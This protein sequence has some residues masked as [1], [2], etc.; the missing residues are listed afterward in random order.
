MP[1]L[2][3]GWNYRSVCDA[4]NVKSYHTQW[5]HNKLTTNS[6]DLIISVIGWTEKR[7][8]IS[9][10]QFQFK[11]LSYGGARLLTTSAYGA[12]YAGATR[13]I[14]SHNPFPCPSFLP[15]F[16]FLSISLPTPPPKNPAGGL[17]ERCS[18]PSGVWG[19]VP[20]ANAFFL[21]ILRFQNASHENIFR[22]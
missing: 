20:A 10:L 19:E 2:T 15:V 12:S 17:G 5:L 9:K 8:L 6:H 3:Q 16:F 18:S 1:P 14:K 22:L 11:H 21:R 7:S 4:S 13:N